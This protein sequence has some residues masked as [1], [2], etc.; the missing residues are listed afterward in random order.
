MLFD[1]LIKLKRLKLFLAI[2]VVGIVFTALFTWPFILNLT[3]YYLDEGDYPLNAWILWHNYSSILNG[4]LL[5]QQNY[6]NSNQF[7][8]Y[9]FTLAYSEFL[10]IPS[11]LFFPFYWITQNLIY[12]YNILYILTFILSFLSS[13]YVLNYFVKNIFASIIGALVYTFNPL[14]FAHFPVHFQLLN[15]YFLPLLFLALYRFL[16]SPNMKYS[17]LFWLTFTL[18]AITVIYFNLFFLLLCV[19]I[20]TPFLTFKLINKEFR[21][22]LTICKL[23]CLPLIIAAIIVGYFYVPYLQFSK[24]EKVTRNINENDYFSA[25]IYDWFISQPQNLISGS[26]SRTMEYIRPDKDNNSY[27]EHTMTITL[28]I[29]TLSVVGAIYM[30]KRKKLKYLCLLNIFIMI[31]CF[32][33]SFGPFLKIYSQKFNLPYYY[34]YNLFSF[35]GGLRVPTRITFLL[36]V[37]LSILVSF[38]ALYVIQEKKINKVKIFIIILLIL[39]LENININNF[40]I[41][42]SIAHKMNEYSKTNSNILN[43]LKNAKTVHLPIHLINPAKES[44]YLTWTIYTNETIL[45]GYSGYFPKDREILE[46]LN[47]EIKESSVKRLQALGIDYIVL[48]TDILNNR[49]INSPFF[50]DRTPV[51]KDKNIRIFDIKKNASNLKVCDLNQ[52]LTYCYLSRYEIS[53]ENNNNCYLVNKYQNRYVE[54]NHLNGDPTFVRLPPVLEPFEKIHALDYN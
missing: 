52:K 29:F 20:L 8:P 27:I 40:Q 39:I 38:G 49:V 47:E 4:S 22:I 7:Y 19:I 34:L 41:I 10:F 36:Y 53:I 46:T 17:I 54:L 3:S 18:N 1:R 28:V 13:F 30:L 6:F 12:S 37:P 33:I 44:M 24:F 16:T 2:T 35:L 11:L 5:N 9:P 31:V 26:L 51:F 50:K 21:Y 15:K 48:H 14:T 23:S 42:N 45:N 25:S 43:L 32:I